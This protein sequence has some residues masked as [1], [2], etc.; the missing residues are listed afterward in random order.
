MRRE[1]LI[2]VVVPGLAS[3][4]SNGG[5]PMTDQERIQG[6]WRLVSGERQGRS[7][8]DDAVR[9]VSL[10]FVGDAL[11]TKTRG[12]ETEA[13]FELI[14]G[15]EPKGIDLD[16]A[17]AVGLGIYLLDGDDLKV[18]HGEVGDPR[19]SGFG[20]EEGGPS[21]TLVLRRVRQ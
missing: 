18:A 4:G 15:T 11:T 5:K 7:L 12:R 16:M 10:I 17:G 13:R 3:G 8:P 20:A 14:P 19:P 1:L 9:D 6:T 2:L 21:T